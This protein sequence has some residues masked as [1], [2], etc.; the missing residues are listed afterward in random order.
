MKLMNC[1]FLK[2]FVP[3]FINLTGIRKI[4]LV[5]SSDLGPAAA[6]MFDCSNDGDNLCRTAGRSWAPLWV[7]HRQHFGKF[8]HFGDSKKFEEEF[9][10]NYLK[11][12]DDSES[13]FVVLMLGWEDIEDA[14]HQ[15]KDSLQIF[16]ELTPKLAYIVAITGRKVIFGGLMKKG[17]HQVERLIDE[18]HILLFRHSLELRQFWIFFMDCSSPSPNAP[19]EEV[20]TWE[21]DFTIAFK[22]VV[23]FALSRATSLFLDNM[24]TPSPF[25][26]VTQAEINFLF[27]AQRRRGGDRQFGLVDPPKGPIFGHQ[28]CG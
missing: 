20:Y 13:E 1:K 7:A 19:F 5:T 25:Y 15:G 10:T 24:W 16:T 28:L 3:F 11:I 9:D 8:F 18:I 21:G 22:A 17:G 4:T 27:F 2:S 26:T 14:Y 12:V 6:T 23:L